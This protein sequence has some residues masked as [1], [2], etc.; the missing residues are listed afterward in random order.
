MQNEH[1]DYCGIDL[2]CEFNSVRAH[3]PGKP[4]QI[5]DEVIPRARG[6]HVEANETTQLIVESPRSE[7]GLT[8]FTQRLTQTD[9]TDITY[10]PKK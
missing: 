7:I 2:D 5:S 4:S 6:A 3:A 10:K 8:L 9:W 1:C